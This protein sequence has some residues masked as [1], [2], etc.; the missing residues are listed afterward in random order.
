MTQIPERGSASPFLTLWLSPRQTIERIVTTR[1]AHLVIALAVLGAIAGLYCQLAALNGGAP[2][3]NAWFWLALIV[4]GG[5]YGIVWL[6][7]DGAILNW[8]GGVLG[9]HAS[10]SKLRAALAWSGVPVIAE[11][12]LLLAVG[13]AMT[14]ND[15]ARIIASL[16]IAVFGLWSLV[17]FL[18]ML[19]RLQHFGFWRTIALYVLNLVA[20]LVLAF[21][22]RTLL[23]QPFNIPAGSMMPTLLVG[24]YFFV[25]KYAYG[26]THYSLPFSPRLFAG[27][28]FASEPRRGDVVVFRLPKD[29]K[30]DFVKRIVGLPG[31]RIQM[32][33]GRLFINGTPVQREQLADLTGEDPCGGGV[34]APVK[35]WRETLDSGASY[36]TLDC[37]DN[38]FYDNT[39]VFTV[40]QGHYFVLGDNRDNSTDSRVLSA[41]GY[42]LFENLIGPAGMIFLSRKESSGEARRD[43]VGTLVR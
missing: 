2:P 11:F 21:A 40:P 42:V 17:V 19:G 18:L 32:K 43:R 23:F 34:A 26:Y 41:I 22:V 20:P 13:G 9:G 31:D 38:G 35:R 29:D 4:G 39:N 8:I 12:V 7:L 37:V 33:E 36:E 27:R 24:D 16:I 10:A 28:I 14:E 1:P 3:A 25:S 5:V 30:T 6:Y 15:A